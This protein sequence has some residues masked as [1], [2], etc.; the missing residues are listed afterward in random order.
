MAREADLVL[1]KMISGESVI[2]LLVDVESRFDGD[3]FTV[4]F[5]TVLNPTNGDTFSTFIYGTKGTYL[6]PI[7]ANHVTVM[8]YADKIDELIIELYLTHLGEDLRRLEMTGYAI[9]DWMKSKD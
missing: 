5:P 7:P 6:V 9:P 2:G 1:F 4:A 8:L 3:R